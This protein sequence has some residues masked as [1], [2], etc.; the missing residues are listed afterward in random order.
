MIF[1][2]KFLSF[3]LLFFIFF[4]FSWAES[5]KNIKKITK[6]K[7]EKKVKKTKKN[8]Q[9]CFIVTAYYSPL[10]NQRYYLTWNYF[11]EVILNWRGYRWASWK[12]VF[13]GMLAAPSSYSFWTKIY[14][15]WLWVAEV[16]DR[17]GAIVKAWVRWHACDRIDIW[18]WWWETW[19]K[20]ALYWGKRKVYWNFV[21]RKRKITLNIKNFQAPNYVLKAAKKVYSNPIFSKWIWTKNPKKDIIALQKYLKKKCLYS[22]KIDWNY[23]NIL[24]IIFK[25]QKKH[26]IIKTWNEAWAWYWSLNTRK[27]FL[28]WKV[29]NWNC[30][31]QYKKNNLEKNSK[32]IVENKIKTKKTEEKKIKNIYPLEKIFEKSV[33]KKSDKE[34]IKKYQKVLKETWLYKWKIDWDYNKIIWIIIDFQLKNKLIKSKNNLAAWFIWPKTRE[35]LKDFYKKTIDKKIEEQRKKEAIEAKKKALLEQKK[36]EIAQIVEKMS[37]LKKWDSWENVKI[38]QKILKHYWYFDYDE[39]WYFWEKTEIALIKYQINRKI[40]KSKDDIWAWYV[41]PTTRKFLKK[42]LMEDKSLISKLKNSKVYATIFIKET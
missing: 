1:M 3:I 27:L 14:F 39:T 38:L 21:S 10:P 26:W 13:S 32:K 34:L 16:A 4:S 6:H 2:K 41:W 30:K 36:V 11:S 31:K 42:D 18:V 25:I 12:R 28:N 19:L 9:K 17:W 35:K 7:I 40:I 23:Y 22:W 29:K 20:R 5:K 15:N 37:K 33:G 24:D 8:K